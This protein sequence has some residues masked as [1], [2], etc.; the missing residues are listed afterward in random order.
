M[1]IFFPAMMSF[2]VPRTFGMP[3]NCGVVQAS[4]F[5]HSQY[6]PKKL[7]DITLVLHV[8]L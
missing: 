1:G 8:I 7:Q 5:I 2:K 4:Y 3:S 6:I